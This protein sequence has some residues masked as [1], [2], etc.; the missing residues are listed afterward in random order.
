MDQR[1]LSKVMEAQALSEAI[2]SIK[3]GDTVQ[4]QFKESE[5]GDVQYLVGMDS[6]GF[7]TVCEEDY[8]IMLAVASSGNW[9]ETPINRIFQ[10]KANDNWDLR[11]FKGRLA[12]RLESVIIVKN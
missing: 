11:W 12:R 5:V 10:F 6:N 9:G 7:L 3:P 8:A 2:D 4:I 1:T